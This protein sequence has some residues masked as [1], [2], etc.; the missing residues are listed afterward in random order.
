MLTD[1]IQ[2]ARVLEVELQHQDVTTD[3][4][5]DEKQLHR[6][7]MSMCTKCWNERGYKLRTFQKGEMVEAKTKRKTVCMYEKI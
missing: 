2:E 3:A 4:W 6:A 1:S 5:K 7:A